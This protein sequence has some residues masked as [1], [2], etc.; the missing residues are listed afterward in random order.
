MLEN[1][2][3]L[4]CYQIR[5]FSIPLPQIKF[6]FGTLAS[7]CA[8]FLGLNTISIKGNIINIYSSSSSN[9]YN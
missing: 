4:Q 3:M 9:R 2:A 5:E 7:E 6:T 8:S 1:K